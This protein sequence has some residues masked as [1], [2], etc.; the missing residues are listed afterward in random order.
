MSNCGPI[1][2]PEPARKPNTSTRCGFGDVQESIH[3]EQS[4][5]LLL[6][7][8]NCQLLG[9]KLERGMKRMHWNIR[10]WAHR[11]R[12]ADGPMLRLVT[13]LRPLLEIRNERGGRPIP[14]RPF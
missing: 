8:V 7:L 10:W 5:P 4:R 11:L 12:M 2:D 9:C 13:P 1:V 6:L 14:R 3:R